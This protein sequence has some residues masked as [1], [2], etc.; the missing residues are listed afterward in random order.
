[1]KQ[2]S[3][4]VVP[5]IVKQK[6][7]RLPLPQQVPPQDNQASLQGREIQSLNTMPTDL[8]V[9]VGECN[10]F[11]FALNFSQFM[12]EL[13]KKLAISIRTQIERHTPSKK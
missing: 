5:H 2:R 7:K 12:R 11:I 10:I 9:L 3:G 4:K 8:K 6:T 13:V 1:M